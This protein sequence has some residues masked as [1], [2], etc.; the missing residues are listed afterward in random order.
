MA[1][2]PK[3]RIFNLHIKIN[4]F[5]RRELKLQKE[6]NHLKDELR[7]DEIL[8]SKLAKENKELLAVAYV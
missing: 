4:R 8:M 6:N 2:L 7:A 3:N 5:K 1:L